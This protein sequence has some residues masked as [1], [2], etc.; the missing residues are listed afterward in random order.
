MSDTLVAPIAGLGAYTVELAHSLGQIAV[1]CLNQ[2]MEVVI[3][4]APCIACPVELDNDPFQ[5][6]QERLPILVVLKDI[7]VPVPCEVT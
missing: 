2:Q 1:R 7:F 3:H 6:Q 4:Q 5:N